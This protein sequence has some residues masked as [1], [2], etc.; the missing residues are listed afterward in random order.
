LNQ[1]LISQMKALAVNQIYIPVLPRPGRVAAIP[2]VAMSTGTSAGTWIVVPDADIRLMEYYC[3]Q[4]DEN[5][6]AG[7]TIFEVWH[8]SLG[9]YYLNHQE[10]H[11]LPGR[12]E[13]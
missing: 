4:T 13:V 6:P 10:E 1:P 7:N 2:R 11:Y 12:P 8:D 3:L 9:Y 5:W